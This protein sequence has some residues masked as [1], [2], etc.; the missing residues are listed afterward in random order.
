M[1][2]HIKTATRCQRLT[3]TK[4]RATI[5]HNTDC[6]RHTFLHRL[7]HRNWEYD[8]IQILVRNQPHCRSHAA[9]KTNRTCRKIPLHKL[10]QIRKRRN[11][12]S[13]GPSSEK[14]KF[15]CLSNDDTDTICV[16]NKYIKILPIYSK[17]EAC[18]NNN[19]SCEKC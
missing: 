7:I 17:H 13:C 8:T 19:D 15:S 16:H 1:H 4:T 9:M 3:C 12:L 6:G 14:Q 2:Y 10:Q 11:S 18:N 5:K